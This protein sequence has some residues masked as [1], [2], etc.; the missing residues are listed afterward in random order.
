[1]LKVTQNKNVVRL[2]V[3]SRSQFMFKIHLTHRLSS[4][5]LKPFWLQC[6]SLGECKQKHLVE[7]KFDQMIR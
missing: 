2:G 3:S 4:C 7:W 1:M 6:T 5:V